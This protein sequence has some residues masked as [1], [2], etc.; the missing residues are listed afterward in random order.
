MPDKSFPF[1]AEH[2]RQLG[3]VRCDPSGLVPCEHVRLPGRVL[4][5][6][7][8]RCASGL[9][10]HLIPID[11]SEGDLRRYGIYMVRERFL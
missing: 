3:N 6:E 4:L 1:L 7:H 11:N 5:V 9:L 8:G 10:A 2:L